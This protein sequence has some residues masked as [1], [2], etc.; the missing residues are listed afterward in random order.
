MTMTSLKPLPW[1]ASAASPP[2]TYPARHAAAA[3]LRAASAVL[4]RLAQRVAV[5]KAPVAE[6]LPS[7]IEF[8]A[9]AGAPEGALYLD[10]ELVG[11]IPGVKRL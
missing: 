9:A 3:T 5:P 10:G 6:P 11:W 7:T 2:W 4:A 8:Y 1:R